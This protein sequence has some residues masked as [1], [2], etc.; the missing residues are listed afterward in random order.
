MQFKINNKNGI[1]LQTKDKYCREDIEIRLDETLIPSGILDITENGEHDVT[2]YEKVNV[3][4]TGSGESTLKK[5]LDYT[6]T[7]K[8]MFK[9]NTSITDLTGLFEYNDTENV[10]VMTDM[11]NECTNL[12]K[13]PLINTAKVKRFD[14]AFNRCI[15]MTNIEEINMHSCNQAEYMFNSCNYIKNIYLTNT[16]NIT[17]SQSMFRGCYRVTY[18]SPIKSKL[19]ANMSYMYCECKAVEKLLNINTDANQDFS[20]MFRNCEKL[21]IVDISMFNSSSSN[22]ARNVFENCYSL[23]AAIIRNFGS[24]YVIDTYTFNNCYHILG[25]TNATYNPEGLQDGY[26]YV[27]RAM[28]ETLQSATN[29]SALQYRALEDYT[30]DGTTTGELDLAKMNGMSGQS[31]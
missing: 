7:T 11:C 12:K 31:L 13:F 3:N 10:E 25:T 4:V 14:Y 21:K 1:T 16:E 22:K 17:S 23:K 19:I 2:S 29:W 18:I 24:S 30:K 9:D 26:I 8:N 28:I 5:L 20:W 15:S 6:K 27:P